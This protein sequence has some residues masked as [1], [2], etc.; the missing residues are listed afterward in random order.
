MVL[1][2]GINV[3]G[4]RTFRPS[5]LARELSK[6]GIINVGAAGTFIVLKPISEAKLRAELLR[7]LPFEAAIMICSASEILNLPRF[8]SFAGQTTAPDIVRFISVLA[9]C[10]SVL[11][12]IPLSL[13]REGD[14]LVKIVA[15]RGR[16][17]FGMYRRT[18][19]TISLLNQLEKHLGQVATTRNWNTISTIVQ[20]LE[21]HKRSTK[22]QDP[23]SR[24]T[25]NSK[26]Q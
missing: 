11:P 9:E 22:L 6:Y 5:T 2:K 16:F 10:P 15:V 20:I 3:G 19:R 12:A 26:L 21:S 18:M 8:E 17:V 14:W 23:S 24:E 4:H 7:K 1:I 25:P 13:P